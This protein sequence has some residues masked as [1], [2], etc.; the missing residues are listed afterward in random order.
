MIVQRVSQDLPGLRH[1]LKLMSR[2]GKPSEISPQHARWIGHL[3]RLRT[4]QQADPA[5]GRHLSF[6]ELEG[7]SMLE[8]VLTEGKEGRRC[9]RCKKNTVSL[10]DCQHC[11]MRLA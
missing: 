10:F 7:L 8:E 4:L 6:E 9:P 11:G 3:L 1:N 2:Q 5:L